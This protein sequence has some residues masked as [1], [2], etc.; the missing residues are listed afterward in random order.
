VGLSVGTFNL[1]WA[2]DA[3]DGRSKVA[4][5]ENADTR[6]DW[7]WKVKAIAAVI[8]RQDLDVVGV[9]E[10]GGPSELSDLVTA[11]RAAGGP[12]YTAHWVAGDDHFTQQQVAI[13]SRVTVV[14]ARRWSIRVSKHLALDVITADGARVTVVVAHLKAGGGRRNEQQ[15]ERQA[16][17]LKV[18]AERLHPTQPVILLGDLNSAALPGDPAYATSA[19]GILAGAATPS[20]DD[21]CTDSAT[22]PEARASH[23]SGEAFDRVI[24]CGL[25]MSAAEVVPSESVRGAVDPRDAGSN[26]SSIPIDAPPFRD[27]SDHDLVRVRLAW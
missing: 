18:H 8:A 25:T 6:R 22:F 11:I 20:P 14:D 1:E 17:A 16:H 4:D 7:Q 24:A 12:S 15:R 10:L 13:L 27:V 19:P 21:D 9:Q 5:R 23:R 26:W 3:R 2:F